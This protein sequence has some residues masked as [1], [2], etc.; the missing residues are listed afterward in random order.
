MILGI[1]AIVLILLILGMCIYCFRTCFYS[2]KRKSADPY[3]PMTGQQFVEV[4]EKIFI[5]FFTTK[6]QGSGIGLALWRQI[7]RLRRGTLSVASVEGCT[8]FKVTFAI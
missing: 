6:P 8:R 7:I 5:P 2:K 1:L 4:Q 3:K